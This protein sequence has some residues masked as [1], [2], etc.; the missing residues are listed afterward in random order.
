MAMAPDSE[1]RESKAIVVCPL[2]F[3]RRVLASAGLRE[4][5]DLHC[6]GPGARAVTDWA[7]GIGRTNRS[8]VLAGLA[9]AL[10]LRLPAESAHVITEVRDERGTQ[11][12]QA[13]PILGNCRVGEEWTSCIV[14]ST[15]RLAG[16]AE[17]KRALAENTGADLVDQESAAFARQAMELGWRWGIV[18]GI[19]DDAETGLPRGIEK[20]VDR[21]GRARPM[22]LIWAVVLRPW[23]VPEI[24]SLRTSGAAGMRGAVHV[25]R[26]LLD[27]SNQDCD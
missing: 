18:R 25:I 20:W 21:M 4:V 15:V 11:A 6:C 22:R 14:A 5:C 16:N 1:E 17:A 26:E 19:S 10:S 7:R 12:G 23:Q 3:E 24:M 9:G 8:V 2:Q 27:S 13:P